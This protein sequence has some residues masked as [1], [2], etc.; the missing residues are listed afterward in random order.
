MPFFYQYMCFGIANDLA[1]LLIQRRFASQFFHAYVVQTCIDSALQFGVLVELAW[2]VLKPT[3]AILPRWTLVG[4]SLLILAAGAVCWPFC[5]R[6]GLPPLWHFL[7]SLQQ[8]ASILRIL[9]FLALVAGCHLLALGWRDRELQVATG[10]GCYSVVS[11]AAMMIHSHQ[12]VGMS[13]HW[14]DIVVALSYVSSLLYWVVSFAQSEAPRREF[15]PQ[16][17]G[18]L[19]AMASLTRTRDAQLPGLRRRPAVRG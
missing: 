17:R 1:M 18:V 8:T 10:L 15:T 5:G 6:P 2:C 16:M 3:R 9:F 19:T 7:I 4:L 12:K 14:V 13:Y 11:F